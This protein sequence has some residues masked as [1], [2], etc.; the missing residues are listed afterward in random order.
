[1]EDGSLFYLAQDKLKRNY[2]KCT[3]GLPA[4]KGEG[5]DNYGRNVQLL[6]DKLYFVNDHN[7]LLEYDIPAL[8][9]DVETKKYYKGKIK[10]LSV[11]DFAISQTGQIIALSENGTVESVNSQKSKLHSTRIESLGRRRL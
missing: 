6:A 4:D 1:M 5:S 7:T 8:K 11:V 3:T 2:F 9:N 10:S